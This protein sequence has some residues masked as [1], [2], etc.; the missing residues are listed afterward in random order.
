MQDRVVWD[1]PRRGLAS[2]TGYGHYHERYVRQHGEW[3][4]ASLKLTRLHL[5]VQPAP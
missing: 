1:A 3:K 5:D 4:I 2:I